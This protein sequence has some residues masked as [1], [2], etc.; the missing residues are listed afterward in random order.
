M[1]TTALM[2]ALL[3]LGSGMEGFNRPIR[4]QLPVLYVWTSQ[5]CGGCKVF[6]RDVDTDRGD[7][8]FRA[9]LRERFS[10]I[11][12]VRWEEHRFFAWSIK[13]VP[14]FVVGSV[15]G[16][17]VRV[18]GYPTDGTGPRWLS[19]RLGLN[20][21]PQARPQP[22]PHNPPAVR[23]PQTYAPE[24]ESPA[25]EKP[26]VESV[27]E[28][29]PAEQEPVAQPVAQPGNDPPTPAAVRP[30]VAG[31]IGDIGKRLL[32]FLPVWLEIPA[33]GAMGATP[34]G[35]GVL[36][37]WWLSRRRKARR[38]T[39]APSP[40]AP[41]APG[42][43]C[44]EVPFPRF[45]DET[46]QLLQLREAEGRVVALDALRGMVID[47]ELKALIETNGAD[48]AFAR[49]LKDKLDDRVNEIAPV[50]TGG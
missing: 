49:K 33:I 28:E 11:Q 7:P 9:A 8:A 25:E 41:A 42:G 44:C 2:L 47:D 38:A 23:P 6:W 17:G 35:L 4:R 21:R 30:D 45:L 19:D 29:P 20:Y 16:G 12:E 3:T 32:P 34:V 1:R 50:S 46:R 24:E 36:A 14:T 18:E 15:A 5:D 43:G 40:I 26:P 48:A 22:A 27:P 39:P 13:V 31:T 10:G 37:V